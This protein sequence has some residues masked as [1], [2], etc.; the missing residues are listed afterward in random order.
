MWL[1]KLP[2]EEALHVL[3]E[4]L[5]NDTTHIGIIIFILEQHTYSLD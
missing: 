5:E 3:S 4:K 1:D 2:T